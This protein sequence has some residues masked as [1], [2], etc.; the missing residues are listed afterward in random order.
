[1]SMMTRNG[2]PRGGAVAFSTGQKSHDLKG[3]RFQTEKSGRISTCAPVSVDDDVFH[4][5]GWSSESIVERLP[6]DL[7]SPC[8]GPGS[9]L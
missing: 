2:Q 6:G 4:A 3:Y 8:T 1:M 7:V 5:S 9:A